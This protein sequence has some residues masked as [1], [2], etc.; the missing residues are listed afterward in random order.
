MDQLIK[1]YID[2]VGKDDPGVCV[3]IMNNLKDYLSKFRREPSVEI[4]MHEIEFLF[5]YGEEEIIEILKYCNIYIQNDKLVSKNL[6]I[7]IVSEAITKVD[8]YRSELKNS[9]FSQINL[10]DVKGEN[11]WRAFVEFTGSNNY[12]VGFADTIGRR[13]DMEDEIVIMGL[14][15]LSRRNEDFYA[16]YDGHGGKEA[17][18]YA[19]THFHYELAKY[20]IIYDEPGLALTKS[21]YETNKQMCV[22]YNMQPGTCALCCFIR[23]DRI[24][25]ANCGDSRAI[26]GS[27]NKV[28][29][30]LS[31]DHTPE[32]E[33]DRIEKAGGTVKLKYGI[34]RVNGK[35]AVARALGDA[36]YQNRGITYEPDII[37]K[38]IQDD[39]LFILMACDGVWEKIEN[40]HAISLVFE[41]KDPEE[42]ASLILKTAFDLGSGDNVSVVVIYLK[43][44]KD[45]GDKIAQDIRDGKITNG[46]KTSYFD[47]PLQMRQSA[48]QKKM[49]RI[50]GK[51]NR[52]VIVVSS[53]SSSEDSSE[54]GSGSSSIDLDTSSSSSIELDL[55]SSSE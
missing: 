42:S 29:E 9:F 22:N 31:V 52:P 26:L 5:K 41:T 50:K 45:W 53:S 30:V 25:I 27:K 55:S 43:E 21:F 23:Q 15:P 17:S 13:D 54:K 10:R 39:N 35:I 38:K 51:K 46:S 7:D 8:T 24:F 16:V 20:L 36:K 34:Y 49:A 18:E 32:S 12:E 48:K 4:D 6:D 19:A 14:G 1:N 11:I 37:E 28:T 47:R 3:F 33:R 40:E 44:R 2:K